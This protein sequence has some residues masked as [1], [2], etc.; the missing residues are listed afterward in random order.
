MGGLGVSGGIM[1]GLRRNNGR[2]LGKLWEVSESP[3]E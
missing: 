1:G 2:S 3:E